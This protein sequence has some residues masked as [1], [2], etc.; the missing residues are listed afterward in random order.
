[1][2]HKGA[3]NKAFLNAIDEWMINVLERALSSHEA[4]NPTKYAILN[5][6]KSNTEIVWRRMDNNEVIVEVFLFNNKIAEFNKTKRTFWL[7]HCGWRTNTTKRR[8]CALLSAFTSKNEKRGLC[9]YKGTWY[10]EHPMKRV[11]GKKRRR[12]DPH[13]PTWDDERGRAKRKYYVQ[14]C[15]CCGESDTADHLCTFYTELPNVDGL[16]AYNIRSFVRG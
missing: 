5:F 10:D 7:T 1:M 2:G 6:K 15:Q 16:V 4:Y 3:V 8:L 13:I 9:V 14:P 12:F 11:V